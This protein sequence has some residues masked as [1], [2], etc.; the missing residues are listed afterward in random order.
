M[1]KFAASN[2]MCRM[3]MMMRFPGLLYR[4]ILRDA[5]CVIRMGVVLV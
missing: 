3:S 2:M 1:R 4:G 5:Y